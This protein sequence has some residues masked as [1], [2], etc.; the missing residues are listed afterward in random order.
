MGRTTKF[1][2]ALSVLAASSSLAAEPAPLAPVSAWQSRSDETRCRVSRVFG[3]EGNRHLVIL[4]QFSPTGGVSLTVAGPAVGPLVSQGLGSLTV[5][6]GV[7][8]SEA[9][10]LRAA[11]PLAGPAV[12][13]GEVPLGRDGAARA[14]RGAAEELGLAGSG[15]EVRFRTGPLAE[16]LTTLDTCAEGLA[17]G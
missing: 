3:E 13:L 7:S 6:D 5:S 12:V 1:F 9:V 4:E 16:V 10:A 14:Q 2:A 11:A 8:T 17:T 15:Q